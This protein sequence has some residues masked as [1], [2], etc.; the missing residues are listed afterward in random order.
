MR[1]HQATESS[2]CSTEEGF[3]I[4]SLDF[5]QMLFGRTFRKV[6]LAITLSKFDRL[7]SSSNPVVQEFRD[8]FRKNS[9]RDWNTATDFSQDD[10]NKITS[11]N[12]GLKTAILGSKN[13]EL[14][15]RAR[16]NIR[17][18]IS[19][20]PYTSLFAVSSTGMGGLRKTNRRLSPLHVLDPLV[21]ILWQ[22]GYLGSK[23]F[24]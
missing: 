9:S 19:S 22:Y 16:K 15:S 20:Y 3:A 5:S 13:I 11:V 1:G 10:I 23:L 6:P 21:W 14:N 12:E 4:T 2:E 7:F 18:I 8:L 24:M 17:E